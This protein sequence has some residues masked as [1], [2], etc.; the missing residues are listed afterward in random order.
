MDKIGHFFRWIFLDKEDNTW[1]DYCK[2]NGL[3][4]EEPKA[5]AKEE[6]KTII[7]EKTTDK[8][9]TEKLVEEEVKLEPNVFFPEPSNA[10][11]IERCKQI[12]CNYTYGCNESKTAVADLLDNNRNE[13]YIV[14]DRL[15]GRSKLITESLEYLTKKKWEYLGEVESCIYGWKVD[16]SKMLDK[17]YETI[18]SYFN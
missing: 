4:K 18:N 6:I 5:E 2:H 13:W 8:K 14:S 3:V 12:I 17:D 10:E 7:L 1:E 9:E 11:K 15:N 16:Y